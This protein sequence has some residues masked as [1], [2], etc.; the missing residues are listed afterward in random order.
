ME[1]RYRLT[2]GADF[3]RVREQGRSWAQPLLVLSAG[4][5]ELG[6]TRFGFIVSR[7]VGNAVVRNRV[8]RRLREVVRRHQGEFPSG[9]DVV[10]VAR[11]PIVQADFVEIERA[12]MQALAR[13]RSWLSSAEAAVKDPS[14][15]PLA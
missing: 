3:A 5:N 10:L 8:R 15:E 2:H 9:W 4:R 7:R 12:L 1:R 14:G 11:P 13:A 6:C